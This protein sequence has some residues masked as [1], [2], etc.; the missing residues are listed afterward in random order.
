MEDLFGLKKANPYGTSDYEIFDARLKE[1]N[2]RKLKKLAADVGIM[3][4]FGE[5]GL[6]IALRKRFKQDTRNYNQVC[7]LKPK[8]FNIDLNDAE[9][10]RLFDL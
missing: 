7:D 2:L 8:K 10:R 9:N 5:K 1:M 4:E 6:R 3:G